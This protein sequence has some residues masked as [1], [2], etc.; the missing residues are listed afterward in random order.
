VEIAEANE[1][2]ILQGES[3]ASLA[4]TLLAAGRIPEAV[5]AF[6][7]A[8]RRYQRKGAVACAR[9]LQRWLEENAPELVAA[10]MP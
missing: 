1:Y 3:W 4:R 7:Q 2:A 5:S 6:G 8:F 10:S 9:T